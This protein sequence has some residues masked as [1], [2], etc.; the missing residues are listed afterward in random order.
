MRWACA[1]HGASCANGTPDMAGSLNELPEPSKRPVFRWQGPPDLTVEANPS[2]VPVPGGQLSLAG[3]TDKGDPRRLPV[4]GDLAHIRLAGR[5]F[6][7]HYAVPMERL[8]AQGAVLR[9]AGRE[10]GD[11]IATLDA[12]TRFAVL[13]M[14]GG[15]AWGQVI[16]DAGED[17]LVG[18]LPLSVLADSAA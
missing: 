12:G 16:E 2:G 13:D 15:W 1:R 6:V 14:A 11:E 8:L 10:E 17:G 18:Y 9:A 7:P 5:W 3:P 4:R